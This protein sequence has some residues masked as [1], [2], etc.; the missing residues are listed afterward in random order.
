MIHDETLGEIKK[1]RGNAPKPVPID[2][3][4]DPGLQD[5]GA[6]NQGS[7]S[8]EP[9]GLQP[10]SLHSMYRRLK[11]RN[12]EADQVHFEVREVAL[13]D[14]PYYN[15]HSPPWVFLHALEDTLKTL[16]DAGRFKVQDPQSQ[17]TSRWVSMV[18]SKPVEDHV[19][20]IRTF[21]TDCSASPN[22]P[23]EAL[24]LV[25]MRM[26]DIYIRKQWWDLFKANEPKG[27]TSTSCILETQPAAEQQQRIHASLISRRRNKNERCPPARL[28]NPKVRKGGDG[29][30]GAAS[31]RDTLEHQM[32]TQTQKDC[33]RKIDPQGRGQKRSVSATSTARSK[34]RDKT[35]RHSP[36]PAMERHA[37]P[38]TPP[39]PLR[40]K[41]LQSPGPGSGDGYKK[42]NQGKTG[43]GN[44]A[45]TLEH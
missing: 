44:T 16:C 1:T 24:I 43:K 8:H 33:L 32:H 27:R 29:H 28:G 15:K 7:S 18:D 10:H 40:S 6:R 3:G 11:D 20:S 4:T 23:S 30:T 17:G 31:F 13:G 14:K 34:T 36:R 22:R 37:F 25:S 19:H 9:K 12:G 41:D 45:R 5:K 21:L 35:R 2:T 42:G 39:A 26:M 38:P